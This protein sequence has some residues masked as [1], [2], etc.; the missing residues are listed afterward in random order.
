MQRC[1]STVVESRV[2][3]LRGSER[4][5]CKGACLLS[6]KPTRKRLQDPS[7]CMLGSVRADHV[8]SIH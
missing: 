8:I 4:E 3:G 7:I 6:L 1:D 2:A 5:F